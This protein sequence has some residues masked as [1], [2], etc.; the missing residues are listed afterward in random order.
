MNALPEL[1]RQFDVPVPRYTSYPTAV[2]FEPIVPA[3]YLV[4]LE[5]LRHTP[6]PISLYIHIP[7]CKT[8]CLYC[9]CSVI[10]N[11]KPEHIQN[12]VEY[13]LKEINLIG[14]KVGPL[15]IQQ[16]HF[17]GGTPTELSEEQLE[18]IMA[19]IRSRFPFAKNAEVAM[20]IDPRTVVQDSGSKLRA[21]KQLGFNRVSFGV[22]DVD[23]Q[24][25]EAVKRR[26]SYAI[27]RE[28]YLRARALVFDG[29]NMDLIYGLP[30][31]S[32]ASFAH[33]MEK[34][35]ELR[36][37]RI[38][39]FSYAK[40]PHLKPHQKAIPEATLPTQTEKL[41]IYLTARKA[42]LTAGYIGIGMDHFALEHDALV[43]ARREGKLQRNFQG[44]TVLDADV[45]LGLGVTAIGSLQE[46][47][48][49]NAKE[50]SEY[51]ALLNRDELPVSRGRLLQHDDVM[52]RWVIQ[53]LMCDFCI[54]KQ[55]FYH[56]FG[57]A[58]DDYFAEAR[59]N[60]RAI[61]FPLLVQEND[62]VLKATDMGELF[63]RNI[64][65]SFDVY[66]KNNHNFSKA[67]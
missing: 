27:T 35:I 56:L 17:G 58:F 2:Q 8:M 22:Q 45:L 6:I 55:V 14:Q 25:Q 59:E 31:Q 15:L 67:V 16:L 37:D 1:L 3:S 48:F 19:A 11:R 38:A 10:L 30:L 32:R 50:L 60:M 63:I 13:L 24:V 46:G 42:L 9:A 4:H 47:Y 39:L 20:E 64:A 61:Y 33:T 36:P 51:Y 23:P 40:V 18:R 62:A 28:T 65:S 66:L 29:I 49:Q 52:R 41:A 5:Q 21:L 57:T 12:Y 54:D 44:Y 43:K 53:R 34:I 26:Q 7:F